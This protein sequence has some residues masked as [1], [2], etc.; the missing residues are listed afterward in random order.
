MRVVLCGVRGS[1]PAPGAEFVRYGGHTSCLAVAAS[2]ARPPSLLLDA[3]SGMTGV[4]GLLGGRPFRGSV[5]LSH[6]H[7]DHTHGMPFFAA[8][9]ADGSRVDV[10][11]PEQGEPAEAVLARCFSPP[12]F[13]ITPS[14][15]GPGWT[16]SGL[17]EGEHAIEGFRVLARE[18]PHKGGRTFGYRVE[19]GGA[20]LAYLPD[21][22]PTSLGPGADGLGERHKAALALADGADLLVTDAQHL[23]AQFPQVAYLGHASV[24]Y[25]LELAQQA[26]VRELLLFHHAPSRTDDEVEA[27]EAHAQQLAGDRLHVRAAQEGL[28]VDLPGRHEG[29]A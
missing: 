26:G 2:A 5:L 18:I 28:V 25:D 7:W 10:L 16:F 4:T 22:S 15:L 9:G 21:H 3:G 1:S 11:L 12:H 6:L 19:H 27:I 17:D 24:E 8:G 14:Q 13:P 29:D 20:V 23:A